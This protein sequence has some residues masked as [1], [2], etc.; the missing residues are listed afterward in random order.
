MPRLKTKLLNLR[1]Y[2]PDNGKMNYWEGNNKMNRGIYVDLGA[3]MGNLREAILKL[4]KE[5]KNRKNEEGLL[6][7]VKEELIEV[8]KLINKIIGNF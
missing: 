2:L 6:R 1:R 3:V 5:I 4:K 7:P 8:E